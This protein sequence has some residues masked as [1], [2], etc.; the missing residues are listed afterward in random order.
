[1]FEKH[2]SAS[3]KAI[4]IIFTHKLFR[5]ANYSTATI[6][7]IPEPTTLMLF[8]LGATAILKTRRKT[9]P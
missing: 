8:A 2:K 3:P 9:A 5:R 4:P 6:H 7:I 1:V